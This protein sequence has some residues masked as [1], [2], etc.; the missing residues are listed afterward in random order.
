MVHRHHVDS[1]VDVWYKAELDTAFD[2][3]PN[4]IVGVGYCQLMVRLRVWTKV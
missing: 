4:E 3:P 2:H 1:V